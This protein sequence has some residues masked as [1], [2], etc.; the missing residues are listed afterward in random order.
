MQK[1]LKL[2]SVSMLAIV[3]AS[4]ANAAGYTCEELIEYTSC[5]P[6]HWLQTT[7]KQCPTGYSYFTGVC[8]HIE[9]DVLYL[10]LDNVDCSGFDSNS[11]TYWDE[12]CIK[13]NNGDASSNC[14][15]DEC[16][17][18]FEY[19]EPSPYTV[20][21]CNECPAGSICSGGTAGATPCPAGSYCAKAGLSTVSGQC[22]KGTYSVGGA[23]S[24]ST[25]PATDLTDKDGATVV[26]TTLTTG[27][28]TPSACVV[29]E[30]HY[31]TDA[32]GTYHFKSDCGLTPWKINVSTQEECEILGEGWQWDEEYSECSNDNDSVALAPTTEEECLSEIESIIQSDAK[33]VDGKCVC[34]SEWVIDSS[35]GGLA[36]L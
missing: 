19:T 20:K 35:Y 36:C 6:G 7:T 29:G 27:A 2:T 13:W 33:W 17:R 30:E 3:A 25:C 14:D 8:N 23:V 32:K 34:T 22:S 18:D 10:G 9:Q 21:T 5:N 24:C 31:F 26:A 4:G 28:T 15:A 16:S 1:I 12:A 11:T